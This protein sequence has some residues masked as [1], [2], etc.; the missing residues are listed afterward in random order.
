[1]SPYDQLQQQQA[2]G[3][4]TWDT[5]SVMSHVRMPEA[6]AIRLTMRDLNSRTH[7]RQIQVGRKRDDE[8]QVRPGPR[9]WD[10]SYTE[11]ELR[12]RDIEWRIRTGLDGEEWVGLVEP[13]NEPFRAPL[14]GATKFLGDQPTFFRNDNTL[15]T[16]HSTGRGG[17]IMS[18]QYF[19]FHKSDNASVEFRGH[20]SVL[21]EFRV[22]GCTVIVAPDSLL[23]PGR[24]AT[25]II[26]NGGTLALMDGATWE[27]WNNDFGNPELVVKHGFVQGGLPERPLT[28]NCT[29]G[30][31]FKN[32]TQADHPGL[33]DK[34]RSRHFRRG[35]ALVFLSGA[36]RSYST[37]L[38]RARLVIRPMADQSIAPEPDSE[39]YRKIIQ[40]WPEQKQIIAWK[41]RLPRGLDVYIGADVAVDGVEFT[42]LRQGGILVPDRDAADVWQ[43]VYFGPSNAATG[44]DLFTVIEGMTD[45]ASY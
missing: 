30:L 17:G 34:H 13:L 33:S 10:G 26:S 18:S 28:R 15:A 23:Q 37:D 39:Q 36:L 5:T 4:N 22:H 8:E 1:M 9:T 11:I 20:V 43:H 40:R 31:A 25:P 2:E 12:Y 42:H 27:S 6:L 14:Q 3:W 29:L 19:T 24:G 32:Y 45:S 44:Q 38:D 21:D 41:R 35:T 7:L 16:A